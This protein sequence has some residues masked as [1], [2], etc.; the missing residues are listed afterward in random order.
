MKYR[1]GN[2][3]KCCAILLITSHTSFY[4]IEAETFITEIMNRHTPTSN[5]GLPTTENETSNLFPVS[6]LFV[7]AIIP[8]RCL[9]T[10]CLIPFF[11]C[12]LRVWNPLP[13]N[14]LIKSVTILLNC[15]ISIF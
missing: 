2:W 3:R 1:T 10:D 14:A 6:M 13:E 4:D 15:A 9:E 11:Y 8:S 12:C 7:F 5:S